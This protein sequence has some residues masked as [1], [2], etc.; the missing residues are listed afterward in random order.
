[1]RNHTEYMA[2][3]TKMTRIVFLWTTAY[4]QVSLYI[5]GAQLLHSCQKVVDSFQSK[6]GKDDASGPADGLLCRPERNIQMS[7]LVVGSPDARATFL[8]FNELWRQVAP[9]ASNLIFSLKSSPRRAT[10]GAADPSRVPTHPTNIL[11][12]YDR[13]SPISTCSTFSSPHHPNILHVN[14]IVTRVFLLTPSFLVIVDL[15]HVASLF[16]LVQELEA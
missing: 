5:S 12:F 15:R 10:K 8:L 9:P 11:R 7:V 1:M 2:A 13:I 16:I 14:R 3:W 4:I 6:S